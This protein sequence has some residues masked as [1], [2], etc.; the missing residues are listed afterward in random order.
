MSK[1]QL[2]LEQASLLLRVLLVLAVVVSTVAAA[3]IS[4]YIQSLAPRGSGP[5]FAM[6][7]YN[8]E[9]VAISLLGAEL[10]VLVVAVA[11]STLYFFTWPFNMPQGVFRRS[12][13]I[14]TGIVAGL[15]VLV[16]SVSRALYGGWA[17]PPSWSEMAVFVGAGGGAL[18]A[19]FRSR[20]KN[21]VATSLECYAIGTFGMLLSDVIRTLTGMVSSPGGATIWGGGGLLDFVFWFGIYLA[22]GSAIFGGLSKTFARVT[23]TTWKLKARSPRVLRRPIFSG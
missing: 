16:F 17:L 18:Y 3:L 21:L 1:T 10:P 13:F 15:S 19:W 22:L 11:V 23:K 7:S 12:F 5:T 14:S 9:I 20:G 6:F 8:K 2:S 4:L